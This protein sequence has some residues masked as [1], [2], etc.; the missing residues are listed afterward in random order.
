[1]EPLVGVGAAA[2]IAEVIKVVEAAVDDHRRLRF[3]VEHLSRLELVPALLDL[4]R[5]EEAPGLVLL[6]IGDGSGE[7]LF[8]LLL[9][10]A[11]S[12]EQLLVA[13]EGV[14]RVGGLGDEVLKRDPL[15]L[16][17]VALRSRSGGGV[18]TLPPPR[19]LGL[20]LLLAILVEGDVVATTVPE[21][22]LELVPTVP[23]TVVPEELVALPPA[24]NVP[25][26]VDWARAIELMARNA[27]ALK[28]IGLMAVS[29]LSLVC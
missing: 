20:V 27:T 2:E 12:S 21:R 19:A 11:P 8:G 24:V 26:T 7:L 18:G 15:D 23:L 22:E 16:L 5:A 4:L 3:G 29:W 1:M 17:L 28:I 13:R 25:V 10:Q 6:R 9:A 14:E